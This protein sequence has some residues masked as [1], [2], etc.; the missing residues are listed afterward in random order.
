MRNCAT[1]DII[2]RLTYLFLGRHGHILLLLEELGELG[3]P[4]EQL[5]GS[6]VEVGAEL[7]E[8]GDLSVLSQLEFEPA[9][10]S[11]HGLDL[12]GGTHS[13]HRETD[14]DRRADA[15]VEK[16]SLQENLP[17][18]DRNHVGGDI[19]RDVAGL[20]LDHRQ[21]GQGAFIYQKPP[22]KAS[23]ILAARSRS[24]ECR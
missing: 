22:P 15:L 18:C 9:R 23:L 4:V 16:L 13:R 11:F 1:F 7:G 5:L 6:G 17:V 3:A 2:Q 12:R 10:H 19:G 8:G 21:G 20:G 14:V 24:R